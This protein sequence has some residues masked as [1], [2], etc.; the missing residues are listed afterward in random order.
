MDD[1]LVGD[2]WV[3]S[4]Q[5]NMD[6]LVSTYVANDPVLA[7]AAGQSCAPT[8]RLL[9]KGVHRVV[10]QLSTP[11]TNP[12]FQRAPPSRSAFP[13]AEERKVSRSTALMVGAVG[14]TPSGFWLQRRDV[15]AMMP[16]APRP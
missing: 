15:S 5:S 12:A 9:R 16:H 2:V 7:E 3:G 11:E 8:I 1:V 14:G 6:T 13:I 4:G 10:W